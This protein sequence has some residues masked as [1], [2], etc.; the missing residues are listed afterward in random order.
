[1]L[2][3]SVQ[4]VHFDTRTISKAGLDPYLGAPPPETFA[5]RRRSLGGN[6]LGTPHEVFPM[7]GH[8]QPRTLSRRASFAAQGYHP[9]DGHRRESAFFAEQPP[10][11]QS[12]SGPS[13]FSI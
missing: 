6:R 8:Q 11:R 4:V 7:H 12:F 3:N 1:M 10:L 2:V 9:P 5:E 13:N